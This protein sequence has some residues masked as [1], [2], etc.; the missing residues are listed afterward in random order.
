[1]LIAY[2]TLEDHWRF[3]FAARTR[4][5]MTLASSEPFT[6]R[7]VGGWVVGAGGSVVV[8]VRIQLFCVNCPFARTTASIRDAR[9]CVRR[10][11]Q[12]VALSVG[13]GIV[14][15]LTLPVAPIFVFKRRVSFFFRNICK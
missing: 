13:V 14:T 11:A 2:S 4:S 5:I 3:C 12:V 9:L 8:R 1:M 7:V 6:G 10:I 15:L